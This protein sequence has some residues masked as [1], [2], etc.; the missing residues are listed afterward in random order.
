MHDRMGTGTVA[1]LP[2]DPDP[3]LAARVDAVLDDFVGRGAIVGAVT[4][5]ARGGRLVHARA[6]GLADRE[7][8][9]PMTVDTPFRLASVTKPF[10]TVAA[11]ALVERGELELD[12]PI[13]TWLPSFRPCFGDEQPDI[14]LRHLLTHTS[15]LGYGFFQPPGGPYQAAGVSDGIDRPGFGLD[16]N[17]R[18]LAGVPLLFRPGS[19]WL[20]SLATDVLGAVVA[21]AGGGPLPEVVRERV[22]GPLGLTGAG[23]GTPRPDDLATPY[24]DAPDG[25]VRM[26][27][28]HHLPF[29]EGGTIRFSPSRVA[30]P[31]AYPSGGAGMVGTP[32]DALMLLETL[33]TGGGPVLR[34]ETVAALGSNAVGDM[35]EKGIGAG[36]G[37]GLGVAVLVD[38]AAAATPQNPGT[39]RWG[40]VYGHNW[41]VDPTAGLTAV[42]MTNTA[43]A[44]MNGPVREAVRDAVYGVG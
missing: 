35:A 29:G 6:A 30:D 16:E 11:L 41:F 27:D 31:A 1:A 37:F 25:P 4:L 33:R 8:G 36:W 17:L 13:A 9:R 20:Y 43:V 14:T 40:G 26:A 2:E 42:T 32:G 23:F 24:A 5:V 7:G 22:T 39:W 21:A 15:G 3:A 18:R 19:A 38:P 12:A 34:P 10:V 44:G 28:P